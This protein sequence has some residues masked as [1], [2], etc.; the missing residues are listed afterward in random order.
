M[1]KG[2]QEL[3]SFFH[4]FKLWETVIMDNYR[5]DDLQISNLFIKQDK[6]GF[7]FGTDAVLLANFA[8]PKKNADILDIGTGNGIIPILLSA[9]TQAQKITGL[10][11]Q[12]RSAEL[13]KENIKLNK[14][15]SLIEIIQGD[16]KDY[17]IFPAASFDY[18]TCNP[19]Y[20]KVGT[21]LANPEDTLAIARHEIM[22]TL[23]DIIKASSYLLKSKGK[24]AMVHKPERVAE[25]I[26]TMKKHKLEAKRLLLVYPR[27]GEKPCLALVEGVKDGGAELNILPP[28]YVYDENGNY[29]VNIADL[30]NK[31]MN[32]NE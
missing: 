18:I 15:E 12:E 8:E 22:C 4:K 19:P 25:I 17:S 10:E 2:R 31:R 21:G 28:L 6:T 1:G 26:Y 29:S 20:K 14:L 11:I 32:N 24:L 9:K 30:Y 13:A 23:E 7:C 16:I 5:I 27:E 3:S